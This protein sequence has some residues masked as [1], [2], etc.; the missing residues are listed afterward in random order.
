[1]LIPSPGQ[2]SQDRTIVGIGTWIVVC[3]ALALYRP[4]VV[5]LYKR[6]HRR[7]KSDSA[8]AGRF[9]GCDIRFFRSNT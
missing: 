4:G 5:I 8:A 9:T 7:G 2:K 1:M 6:Q 3:D